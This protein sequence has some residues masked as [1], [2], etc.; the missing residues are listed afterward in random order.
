MTIQQLDKECQDQH[1]ENLIVLENQKKQ[2][3]AKIAAQKSAIEN[4]ASENGVLYSDSSH[5]VSLVYT[6]KVEWQDEF[7]QSCDKSI[8][9]YDE[10]IKELQ[11]DQNIYKE[12]RKTRIAELQKEAKEVC[13]SEGKGINQIWQI[14]PFI[15]S[16]KDA[17]QVRI[18]K[19]KPNK[20]TGNHESEYERSW[21]Y[22]N[23][24]L[25]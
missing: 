13:L 3:E 15:K 1:I 6:P 23:R 17:F 10:R 8:A 7:V 25:G 5:S 24:F 12:Q 20:E 2:I 4:Y 19:S 9:E 22:K 21:I 16:L 18:Q 14:F 11:K